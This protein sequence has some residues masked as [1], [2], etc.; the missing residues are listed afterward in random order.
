MMNK[1]SIS[2]KSNG[3]SDFIHRYGEA[4]FSLT[5]LL[6]FIALFYFTKDIKLLV[7]NTTVDARFWPKVCCI[8]GGILSALLFIQS[9]FFGAVQ[10]KQEDT[11]KINAEE[12]EKGFFCSDAARTAATFALTLLYAALLSP[13]GFVVSALLYLFTLFMLLS[14]KE[15]RKIWK[16]LLIDAV[17]T[18]VVYILF[19]YAFQMLLP[20]GTIW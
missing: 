10:K 11:G 13:I 9:V 6:I 4:V 8:C 14:E 18:A 7:V 17:F 1:A 15:G 20:A 16:L 2:G 3:F 5:M 19:R 12:G